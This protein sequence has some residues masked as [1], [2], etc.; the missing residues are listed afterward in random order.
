MKVVKNLKSV[1]IVFSLNSNNVCLSNSLRFFRRVYDV[2]L[3]SYI[4]LDYIVLVYIV[5]DIAL[6]LCMYFYEYIFMLCK[7]SIFRKKIKKN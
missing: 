7:L 5:L 1:I 3:L 2:I 6:I 4:V